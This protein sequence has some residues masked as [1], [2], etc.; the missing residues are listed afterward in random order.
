V[1]NRPAPLE[2]AV[3][4]S[5][6]GA[7]ATITLDATGSAAAQGSQI[8]SYTW[9]VVTLPD[10]VPVASTQGQVAEVQIAPGKYQVNAGFDQCSWVDI[11]AA[12]T[13]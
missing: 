11:L 10:R 8:K 3:R 2:A 6:G 13:R 7:S 12:N 9:G 4:A 1:I 5:K